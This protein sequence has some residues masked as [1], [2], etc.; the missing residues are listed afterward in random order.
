M[1]LKRAANKESFPSS[2]RFNFDV[3]NNF[4]I[5]SKTFQHKNTQ[6]S[7]WWFVAWVEEW[8]KHKPQ[9]K[10]SEDVLMT[11]NKATLAFV[12]WLG[13]FVTEARR[14]DGTPYPPTSHETE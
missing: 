12:Y 1:T 10:C 6:L 3:D 13:R 4:K 5:M 7:T 9:E 14:Q 2:R 8:N 11:D